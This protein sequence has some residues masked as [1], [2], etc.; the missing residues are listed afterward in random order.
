MISRRISMGDW[1][2]VA[3][4]LSAGFPGGLTGQ[5]TPLAFTGARILPISADPIDEGVLVLHEGRVRLVGPK[6]TAL[7]AGAVERDVTGLVVMPGLVDTHSHIGGVS[8]GERSAPIQ[9]ELRVLD[10]FDARAPTVAKARAGGITTAN[11]MSGS[12]MLASGQ[13]LYLKLR[14]ADTVDSLLIPLED[15]SPAGGLKM[16]N[17]TNSR[18]DPPFPGSRAKSAALVRER[19]IAAR[20]YRDKIIRAA[21]DPDKLPARDL[22]LETLV[23]ALEGKRVVHHHTHRHDDILTVLRLQKEFGFRVVLQHVTDAGKVATEIAAAQAPCSAILIDSP[24]GKLETVGLDWAVGGT[25]EA[26]GVLTAFHTDDPITDSRLF[27]RS[28]AFAVRAGM[29]R[30]GALRA[31]TLSPARMLD[32]DARVGSLEPGKDA[33]FIVL[34]GDPL[35]VRTLVLETWIEGE[36]VFDRSDPKD[37]VFATGGEGAGLPYLPGLCCFEDDAE[38]S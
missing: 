10:M 34:S 6:G 3:L 12:G 8:Y 19:F 2:S 31:L 17:G 18:R 11:I 9:P 27:L 33:D 38:G 15:G 36:K 20:E 14:K 25:L 5:E 13:T 24:G 22:G 16:A 7:P 37:R 32:L 29:S 23:E 26:A 21:G 35:S 30:Q 28:A 4:L 1:I